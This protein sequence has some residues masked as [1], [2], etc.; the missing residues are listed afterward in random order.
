[1]IE[2]TRPDLARIAVLIERYA[3]LPLGSTD[4]SIITVAE[5]LKIDEIFTLDVHHF[6]VVRPAH[7]PAFRLL[8]N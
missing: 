4:A 3:D 8:P 6:S 5:R 2:L 7:V 1:M